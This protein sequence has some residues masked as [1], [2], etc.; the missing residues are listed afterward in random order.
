LPPSSSSWFSP[1]AYYHHRSSFSLP[2]IFSSKHQ[3]LQPKNE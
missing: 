3:K 2:S 1:L